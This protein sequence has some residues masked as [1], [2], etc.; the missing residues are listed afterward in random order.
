LPQRVAEEVCDLPQEALARFNARKHPRTGLYVAPSEPT[1]RRTIKAI[2]ADE[3]DKV[4]GAWLLEQIRE[5]RVDAGQVS[6]RV[7]VALDGKVL[8]GSWA[9][10]KTV[11]TK[12]FSALVHGESV[13]IGQREVPADTTEV[14][15]VQPLLKDLATANG[16]NLSNVVIT[17]DSLHTHRENAAYIFDEGGDYVLTA[18]DNQPTLLRD[19]KAIFDQPSPAHHVTHDKG[20]GRNETR[21]ITVSPDV[22]DLDFPG[23][24]QAW[25]IERDITYTCGLP[26]S[27]EIAYGI[28]SLTTHEANPADVA[29]L[30]RGQWGIE[31]R[32]HHVRDRTF[33]EDR[34]QVRVGSS[35][36]VMATLRNIAISLL[37]LAGYQN[38]AKGTRAMRRRSL[39][40][41][42]LLSIMRI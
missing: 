23:V 42:T 38:I 41:E 29:A 35:P 8:K 13:T 19:I 4:I 36:Q 16:G 37:R 5:G 21:T 34:S 24:Y 14:T 40:I 20:H 17:A 10:V 3:A 33:D 30:V 7:A 25:R 15:Q 27:H 28:T 9:E 39:N 6:G 31:N 12:L 1:I 11:K 2:D 22:A 26:R 32:S 18:K